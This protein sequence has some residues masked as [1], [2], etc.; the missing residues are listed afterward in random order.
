MSEQH[1]NQEHI[2][3]APRGRREPL[4][5]GDIFTCLALKDLKDAIVILG[6]AVGS[7]EVPQPDVWAKSEKLQS[8]RVH[9]ALDSYR[10]VQEELVAYSMAGKP[11][12]VQQAK[13]LLEGLL[14]LREDIDRHTTSFRDGPGDLHRQIDGPADAEVLT[15]SR[16]RMWESHR[17]FL[18]AITTVWSKEE[19]PPML[20][21]VKD[22]IR[23][24]N[25]GP[26]TRRLI[27]EQVVAPSEKA[28]SPPR[29]PDTEAGVSTAE[30]TEAV[31]AGMEALTK[32]VCDAVRAS[33][34]D[35]VVGKLTEAAKAGE[36]S[37]QTDPHAPY[38]PARAFVSL[39]AGSLAKAAE[40]GHIERKRKSDRGQWKYSWPD[41]HAQWPDHVPKDPPDPSIAQKK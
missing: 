21:S 28:E 1:V 11:A 10:A 12:V 2:I 30:L 5:R 26:Q 31:T 7:V 19:R 8:D 15:E 17:S 38:F 34:A 32:E 4:Q 13:Q 3:V 39:T 9:Y 6:V 23:R 37:A 22:K 20:V 41:A 29:T 18:R 24:V 40:R 25:A 36:E 33:S 35:R 16:K 27:E 14:H